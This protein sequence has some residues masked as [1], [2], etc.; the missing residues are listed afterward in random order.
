MTTLPNSQLGLFQED[1]GLVMHHLMNL[2]EKSDIEM[3]DALGISRQAVYKLRTGRTKASTAR[4]KQVAAV[5]GVPSAVMMTT[6]AAA[7]RYVLDEV[8]KGD[9]DGDGGGPQVLHLPPIY[10]LGG[11][12]TSALAA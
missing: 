1:P 12:V 7:I 2:L 4:L 8:E 5:L 9:D 10:A 11:E 3:G 6:P